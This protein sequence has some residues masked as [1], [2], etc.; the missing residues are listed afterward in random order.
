M[1]IARYP[2]EPDFAVLIKRCHATGQDRD[3]EE[4]RTA[5]LPYLEAAFALVGT[6]WTATEKVYEHIHEEYRR[7]FRG[8]RN[9]TLDY[10]TYLLGVG[11]SHLVEG[12]GDG[13]IRQLLSEM[14]GRKLPSEMSRHEV[15]TL[16][17]CAILS[18][19][20]DC[21]SPLLNACFHPPEHRWINM[22]SLLSRQPAISHFPSHCIERLKQ[23]LGPVLG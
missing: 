1:S 8:S 17:F 13:T 14:F 4:F 2:Q 6:D 18:M 9:I 21:V 19:R 5:W 20:D 23:R 12:R 15:Y 3:F 10:E 16:V 11:Y 22:R 7:I